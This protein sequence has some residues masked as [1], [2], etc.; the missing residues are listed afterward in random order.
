MNKGEEGIEVE[1]DGKKEKKILESVHFY[2]F[3][4]T[5]TGGVGEFS[6]IV[7]PSVSSTISPSIYMSSSSQLS[8]STGLILGNPLELS[9]ITAA[10][11][12]QTVISLGRKIREASHVSF[13][14]FIYLCIYF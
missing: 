1:E 4:N 7:F 2:L 14:L 8:T 10:E 12:M 9:L 5:E 11:Q 3:P 6:K 13:K